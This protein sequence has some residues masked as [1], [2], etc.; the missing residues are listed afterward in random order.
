MVEFALVAPIFV[1]L[2]LGVMDFGFAM[3]ETNR[4]ERTTSAAARTGASLANYKYTDYEVLKVVDAAT[5]GIEGL[6]LQQVVV[7]KTTSSDGP[8]PDTCTGGTG[9]DDLCNVYTAEMV[10]E[11]DFEVGFP[12]R[13]DAAPTACDAGSWDAGWCP[14]SSPPPAAQSRER[15]I[16]SRDFL[17]VY[18]EA[19][20]SGVT[21]MLPT[22]VTFEKYA[23]FAI[24]PCHKGD[25]NCEGY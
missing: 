14:M 18:I 24:E 20:Y 5:A 6:E 8:P 4:L 7:Y 1:V 11:D 12:D 21:Q 17:G 3:R 10:A 23:V 2:V 19:R 16:P 15:R 22:G 25:I 9:V 13:G